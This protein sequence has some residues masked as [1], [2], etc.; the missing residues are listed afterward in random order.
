MEEGQE[1]EAEGGWC[2]SP[3]RTNWETGREGRTW[4]RK[5]RLGWG[6]GLSPWRGGG[7]PIC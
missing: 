6:H 5:R 1:M 4:G 3:S 2:S 7:C